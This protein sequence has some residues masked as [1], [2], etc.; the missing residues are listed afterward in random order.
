MAQAQ[1]KL[2]SEG[3]KFSDTSVDARGMEGGLSPFV[4]D[5]QGALACTGPPWTSGA[6][7]GPWL[8]AGARHQAACVESLLSPTEPLNPQRLQ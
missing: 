7:I 3:K 8:R 6:Q 5:D 1:D 4:R 2:A